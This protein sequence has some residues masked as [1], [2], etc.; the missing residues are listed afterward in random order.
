MPAKDI[1]HSIVRRVLE[2]EGWTITDDP[3]HIK[4]GTIHLYI[5]LGA[6]NLIAAKKNGKKIAVE[7]KSFIQ[8]SIINEFHTTIGQFINYR[9]ALKEK[10][11][12]RTLYLAVP[13]DAHQSFFM[14]PFVQGII[15]DNRIKYFVYNIDQEN[16]LKWQN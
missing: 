15:Q 1:Y 2:K 5:D 14:L 10:Q 6:K 9:F 4:Y 13:E 7:I 12:E 3:L 16:I 8:P 11:P